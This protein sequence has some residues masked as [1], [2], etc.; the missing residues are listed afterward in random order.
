MICV[1]V[2]DR[3]GTAAGTVICETEAV[4]PVLWI[5]DRAGVAVVL[6]LTA[7]LA[8]LETAAEQ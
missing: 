4:R 1:T 6:T 8:K 3:A 5:V 2:G 7:D